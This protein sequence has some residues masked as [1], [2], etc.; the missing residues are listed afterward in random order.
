MAFWN[1]GG[2]TFSSC[3]LIIC[4]TNEY[5]IC[6]HLHPW[7]SDVAELDANEAMY[8]RHDDVTSCQ[9]VPHLA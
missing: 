1:A 3:M 7:S 6:K 8:R 5:V 4:A 2:S 9:R